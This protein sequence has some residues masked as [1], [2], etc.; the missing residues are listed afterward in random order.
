MKMNLFDDIPEMV[1]I[2]RL[3]ARCHLQ[4]QGFP[5][6][7]TMAFSKARLVVQQDGVPLHAANQSKPRLFQQC[8]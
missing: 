6:T 7:V 8:L 4:D 5:M 2:H 3:D 1:V